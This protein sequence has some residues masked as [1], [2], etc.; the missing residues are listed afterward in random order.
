MRAT[1]LEV[2]SNGRVELRARVNTLAQ[3]RLN[4]ERRKENLHTKGMT[5]G[6][7]LREVAEIP[8]D[9]LQSLAMAGDK[10]GCVLFDVNADPMSKRK[11]L[12]HVL[13]RWPEFKISSGSI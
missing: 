7:S 1:E 10:D 2:F 8:F 3:D 6:G 5:K 13:A 4:N 12:R 9:F 11:A